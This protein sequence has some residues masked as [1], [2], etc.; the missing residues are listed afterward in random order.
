MRNWLPMKLWLCMVFWSYK[1]YQGFFPYISGESVS[2]SPLSTFSLDHYLRRGPSAPCRIFNS[3][4]DLWPLRPVIP[5]KSWQIKSPSSVDKPLVGKKSLPASMICN[6]HFVGERAKKRLVM[7]V[8]GFWYKQ[9]FFLQFTFCCHVYHRTS[10]L[11]VFPPHLYKNITDEI[12]PSKYSSNMN[13]TCVC[14][15]TYIVLMTTA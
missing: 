6:C 2:A 12:E 10:A 5:P 4:L 14:T 7:P 3:I 8:T 1:E 15:H 9:S 11:I 13:H